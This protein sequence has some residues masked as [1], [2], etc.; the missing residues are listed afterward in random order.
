M[1]KELRANWV[2]S[3][4]EISQHQDDEIQLVFHLLKMNK[5]MNGYA[6]GAN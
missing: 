2:K 3:A 6:R 4:K 5:K 1:N